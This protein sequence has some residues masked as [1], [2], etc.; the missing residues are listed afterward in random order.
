MTSFLKTSLRLF[1]L[2]V[3]MNG[4]TFVGKLRLNLAQTKK[5]YC[6][7]IS[8]PEK[9]IIINTRELELFLTAKCYMRS[10]KGFGQPM[11]RSRV[12]DLR[13]MRQFSARNS[14][15]VNLVCM[16]RSLPELNNQILV[17]CRI[18]FLKQWSSFLSQGSLQSQ[19]M[20]VHGKFSAKI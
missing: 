13:S 2:S 19:L 1:W 6:K 14:S 20:A 3:K 8:W 9:N 10:K 15:C 7:N 16:Q 11:K 17:W 18:N 5:N 4:V 12:L